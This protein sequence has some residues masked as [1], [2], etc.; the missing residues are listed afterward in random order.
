[1]QHELQTR[2]RLARRDRLALDVQRALGRLLSPLWVPLCVAIMRYGF[3]WRIEAVE[4]TRREF[5]RLRRSSNSPLLICANH[6]TML[7]SF[8]IGMALGSPWWLVSNYSSL[9]WNTPERGNFASNW[10]KRLLVY[11]MKC[12]PVERGGDRR[13]VGAALGRLIYLMEKGEA[14]LVFP[15]GGRS[16]TGRVD[17][18]AVTYGVGRIVKALPGC[19]VVCVYLRGAHQ[20]SW[21]YRPVTGE[22]FRVAIETF[23]PKT[24]QKG[25]RGSLDIARQILKRL[26]AME[27]RHFD[28]RE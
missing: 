25:L 9:P 20:D 22:C 13:A 26:A 19:Q 2:S 12:V 27:R 4:Q 21:S 5:A 8:V 24:D 10:W 18:D 17:T 11:V 14:A 28:G 15:E 6:L 1:M 7:D 3:R 23:E 16:R